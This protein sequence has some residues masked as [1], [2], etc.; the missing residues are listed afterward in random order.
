VPLRIAFDLDGVLADMEGALAREAESL[1]G[2]AGRPPEDE[3]QSGDPSPPL[4]EGRPEAGA[5]A[6]NQNGSV[7]ELVR[8]LQK[9][10]LS[11]RQTNR[12]WRHVA[13]FE[14]FWE[15][16]DELEPGLVERLAS[17][18]A[19]H[20][21]EAIF[22]TRRPE[23]AGATSQLQ[24]QRWLES[25][26]FPLPS[27]FVVE[28]SRGRIAAALNLD[29]VVDDSPENCL[30]VIVDSDARAILVWRGEEG[31]LPAAARRLG[32]GIVKS[33]AEC[34]RVLDEVDTPTQDRPSVIDRVLK[35]LG[36]GS[37]NAEPR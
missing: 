3:A 29:F 16:L 33:A 6:S 5:P 35:L 2:I 32:I 7:N 26:G 12:L 9:L 17:L 14:N 24:T 1:F 4:A 18:A 34:L 22:L 21:W 23:T 15:S 27:V 30:D 11:S 8:P 19:R 20:R 28:G 37:E 10:Q 13:Q 25:K 36:L 31:L